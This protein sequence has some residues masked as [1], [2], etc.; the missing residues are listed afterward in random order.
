MST[1]YVVLVPEV[2][3]ER[4]VVTGA[5]SPEEAAYLAKNTGQYVAEGT[6]FERVANASL[7][8]PLEVLD[9]TGEVSVR[10]F[11]DEN[12]IAKTR[13][14]LTMATKPATG[15]VTAADPIEIKPSAFKAAANT[16]MNDASDAAWRHAAEETVATVKA[17]L[18]AAMMKHVGIDK[19][20]FVGNR[21]AAFLDTRMG[22]GVLS[23]SLSAMFP[24]IERT[25]PANMQGHS[26]RMSKELR[27]RGIHDVAAPLIRAVTD[28]L[29][30][31]MV[32]QIESMKASGLEAEATEVAEIAAPVAK[33]E[34]VVT[35]AVA[36]AA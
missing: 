28:P 11:T 27:I 9:A 16:L 5:A 17:P 23:L 21:V 24:L 1:K 3:V 13:R 18:A 31:V 4:R 25:L 34:I 6:V 2:H 35:P 32:T 29:R 8:T 15:T 22:E 19:D 30:T 10:V 36:K 26:A 20:S 7:D 12:T 33:E 14:E